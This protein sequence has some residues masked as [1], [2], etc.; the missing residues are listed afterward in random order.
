MAE[1]HQR[2]YDVI[3]T[4]LEKYEDERFFI[5][6]PIE[7]WGYM[8]DYLKC[9]NYKWVRGQDKLGKMMRVFFL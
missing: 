2:I 6:V 5:C 1:K 3:K 4:F 9:K 8:G 7:E